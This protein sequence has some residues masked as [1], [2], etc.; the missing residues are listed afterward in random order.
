MESTATTALV[1]LV[2]LVPTANTKLTNVIHRHAKMELRV[3]NIIMN[4]SAIVLTAF[5]ESNVKTSSTGVHKVLV[6][7]EQPA[8]SKRTN[9]DAIVHQGGQEKCVMSKWFLAETLHYVKKLI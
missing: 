1:D 8:F 3:L 6:K 4:M 5:K 7:M 9:S 2:S